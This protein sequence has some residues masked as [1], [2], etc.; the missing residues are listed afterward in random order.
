MN[1]GIIQTRGLGDIVIAIPIAMYYI[2]RGYQVHWPID[3]EF[4]PSFVET[5]PKIKF[6]PIYKSSTGKDTANYYY[7]EPLNILQNQF[8]DNIICLYSHLTGFNLGHS[9]LSNSLPFDAYKYAIAK[10]PFHQKWNFFPTRNTIREKKLFDTFDLMPTEDYKIIHEVG[11]N[12]SI[13]IKNKIQQS[14]C[15]I[16]KIEPI[17]NNIFDWIGIIE[18]SKAIYTVDSVYM[19]I[20]DQLKLK[21]SKFAF[22]RSPAPFTPVL[23]EL[24]N[25]IE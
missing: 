15:K 8:C 22:L 3:S 10:V 1:L 16:I 13:D 9:V 12:F 6:Y 23:S 17:T 2:D 11:S 7:N 5:F 25:Y 4:I 19:N 21:N 14:D 24:W 20:I 18:N